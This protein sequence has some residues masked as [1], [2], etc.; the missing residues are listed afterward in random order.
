MADLLTK[1]IV[2]GQVTVCVGCCCGAV[3]RGKPEVPLEWLKEEWRNRGLLKNVHLTV[4]GC[5]GPCDLPNVVRISGPASEIWLGNIGAFRQYADLADWA[6]RSKAAG[7]LLP[8]GDSFQ[9]YRFSPFPPAL[10][11]RQR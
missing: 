11:E 2:I 5:L 9:Q 3:S 10:I 4:S 8:L 1:R 6:C 7:M